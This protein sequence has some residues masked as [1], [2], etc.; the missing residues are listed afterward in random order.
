[1]TT[2]HCRI[3][4][5]RLASPPIRSPLARLAAERF[6]LL[7]APANA[8]P[9]PPPPPTSPLQLPEAGA[10]HLLA[11]PSG[12]GKS[13]RL[14][15]LVGMARTVDWRVIDVTTVRLKARP[16]VDLFSTRGDDEAR[17]AF[18]ASMLSR[19]GLG[20]AHVFL[21]TPGELSDGQR[22]RLRLALCYAKVLAGGTRRATLLVADEFCAVL[23]RVTASV[24]AR[25]LRRQIDRMARVKIPVRAVV[26]TSH[27]DLEPALLPDRIERVEAF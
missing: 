11:G 16:C 7:T 20:E 19:V 14:R 25:G 6:G 27:D 4:R 24:V 23:D 21:R 2:I 10:I 12:G 17:L 13:T 1:M 26:A 15:R 5:T 22:W 9:P 3:A 18:A 8:T